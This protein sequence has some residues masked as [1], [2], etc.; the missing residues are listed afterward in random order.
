M[1]E[2]SKRSGFRTV[3]HSKEKKKEKKGG[4]AAV[5]L[6]VAYNQ[7]GPYRRDKCPD[8]RRRLVRHCMHKYLILIQKETGGDA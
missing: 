3:L 5:R 7:A 6:R 8:E 1:L 4:F 2:G